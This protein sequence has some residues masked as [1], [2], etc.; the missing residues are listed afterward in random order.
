[1]TSKVVTPEPSPNWNGK[2]PRF[3]PRLGMYLCEGC[4]NNGS[5]NHYCALGFCDCPKC[6]GTK[7]AKKVKYEP[8][9]EQQLRI[10]MDDT[11]TIKAN[12]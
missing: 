6:R 7:P 1:M 11:I 4:W 5:R 8:N 12:S 9:G 3:D 2:W 10:S